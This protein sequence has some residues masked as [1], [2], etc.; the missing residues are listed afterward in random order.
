MKYT[1]FTF[2]KKKKKCVCLCDGKW[3]YIFVYFV[4]IHVFFFYRN[5]E[6]IQ[7][8]LKEYMTFTCVRFDA[9]VMILPIIVPFFLG[10]QCGTALFA[11]IIPTCHMWRYF[12]C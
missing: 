12:E 2:A 4:M 8:L 6:K 3:I 10:S 1:K 7:Y 11:T 9:C 5:L